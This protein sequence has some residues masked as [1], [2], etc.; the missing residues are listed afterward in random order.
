[1]PDWL[2]PW[3]PTFETSGVLLGWALFVA[4]ATMGIEKIIGL[5]KPRRS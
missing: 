3:I 1:M 2:A 5:V 4:V